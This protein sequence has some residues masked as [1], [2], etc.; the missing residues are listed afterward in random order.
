[1]SA[2][3]SPRCDRTRALKTVGGCPQAREVP[4]RCQRSRM[5]ALP[6]S[7]ELP[8]QR[9]GLSAEVPGPRPSPQ[10]TRP[11]SFSEHDRL[12]S[13]LLLQ[14]CP[15]RRTTLASVARFAARWW[16]GRGYLPEPRQPPDEGP[17]PRRPPRSHAPVGVAISPPSPTSAELTN[18]PS[19]A[20]VVSP[21]TW[22]MEGLSHGVEM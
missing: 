17:G 10:R 21:G 9:V 20:I 6:Q 8:P 16:Y 5:V 18:H 2:A 4:R 15:E 1:V 14:N 7:D 22:H 19:G 3:I 13:G 11:L 12:I